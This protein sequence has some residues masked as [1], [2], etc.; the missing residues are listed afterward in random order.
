MTVA[1]K[2]IDKQLGLI[3]IT[4]ADTIYRDLEHLDRTGTW[5]ETDQDGVWHAPAW[6]EELSVHYDGIGAAH[7][8]IQHVGWRTVA[9]VYKDAFDRK[10]WNETGE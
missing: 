5:G 2:I 9:K 3:T 1:K 7:P 10:A 8:V 6:A 4:E